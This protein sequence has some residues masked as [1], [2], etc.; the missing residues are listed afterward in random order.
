M[1]I[2]ACNEVGIHGGH[3]L[4]GTS[5]V[6]DPWGELTVVAGR[7]EEV[8]VIDIDPGAPERVRAEFPVLRDRRL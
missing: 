1:W 7:E 5:L 4:G 8:I 3:Q 6:A 2:V